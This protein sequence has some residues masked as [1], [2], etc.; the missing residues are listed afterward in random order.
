MTFI[1]GQISKLS[2][3]N[4]KKFFTMIMAMGAIAAMAQPSPV[5]SQEISGEGAYSLSPSGEWMVSEMSVENC[6]AIRNLFTGQVWGYFGD[7]TDF[8]DRW[9]LAITQCA[10]NDGTIVGEYN[11]VPSY[12]RDGKWTNLKG[13]IRDTYGNVTA[14]VGGITPD[15]SVIVGAMGKGGSIYDEGDVQM[16]YPCIWYRQ[17]DGTYGDPVWLPNPGKDYFGVTPQYVNATCVSDDGKT[18]GVLMR[19]GMGFHHFPIVYTQGEDG[20]W[21]YK[22]LGLELVNPRNREIPPYPG[23]YHGPDLPNYELYM[24]PEQLAAFYEAGPAWIDELYEQGITDEKEITYLEIVFAMEFMSED[25]KALYEPIVTAFLD[26]YPAWEKAFSEYLAFIEKL[27]GEGYYF[28]YNKVFLS[29]DGKYTYAM[30]SSN[31]GTGGYFPIRFETESGKSQRYNRGLMITNITDDYSVLAMSSLDGIAYIYPENS[32]NPVSFLEYWRDDAAISL[33]MEEHMFKQVVKGVTSTGSFI[34]DDQWCMGRP[35][36]TRDKSLFAFGCSSEMWYPEP[37]DGSFVSTF[38]INPAMGE[39]AVEEVQASETNLSINLI[40]GGKI[41]VR[42]EVA[43]LA[44]YDLAGATVYS[45]SNPS[46]VIYTGLPT[47]VYVVRAISASGESI[48]KKALF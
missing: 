33:W 39:S 11:N 38:I 12:W 21:T 8:G 44:V 29:P 40:P 4:M 3:F 34:L 17:E 30:G 41:E 1:A 43:T 6:M 5:P 47:G 9:D 24:T 45:A 28:L 25:Q 31:G 36:A 26:Q 32:I 7:G 15:G 18:I 23:E 13:W 19:S 16:T 42:G 10:A 37:E 22:W 20:E 2:F 46:G 35:V 48:T 14:V 27:D